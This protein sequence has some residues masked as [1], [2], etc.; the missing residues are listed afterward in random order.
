MPSSVGSLTTHTLPLVGQY[1][2]KLVLTGCDG[3]GSTQLRQLLTQCPN[4]RHLDVSYTPIG[5]CSFKRYAAAGMAVAGCRL[6]LGVV[7]RIDALLFIEKMTGGF[8]SVQCTRKELGAT[9]TLQQKCMIQCF[10][11]ELT[12]LLTLAFALSNY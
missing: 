12:Q 9:E 2:Q 11:L 4:V 7:Y 1:V 8:T 5:D 6:S 10:G 3:L